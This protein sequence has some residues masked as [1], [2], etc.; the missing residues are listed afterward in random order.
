MGD[1]SESI[2]NMVKKLPPEYQ[3]AGQSL[4]GVEHLKNFGIN[5]LRWDFSIRF[6]NGEF[7][8]RKN[9]NPNRLT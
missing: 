4:T 6:Q 9:L 2:E 3:E 7:R 1:H 8:H 5:T